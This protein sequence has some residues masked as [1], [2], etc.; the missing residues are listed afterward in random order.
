M[1]VWKVEDADEDWLYEAIERAEELFAE[2]QR[3][4]KQAE[5]S[6]RAEVARLTKDNAVLERKEAE[7]RKEVDA[8]MAAREQAAEHGVQAKFAADRRNTTARRAVVGMRRAAANAKRWHAEEVKLG[9]ECSTFQCEAEAR[10]G[11]WEERTETLRALAADI[12]DLEE[13]ES[14]LEQE[15]SE[16][17]SLGAARVRENQ[18][19]MEALRSQIAESTFELQQQRRAKELEELMKSSHEGM[20]SADLVRCIMEQE[21]L[22]NNMERR[23]LA[24]IE[25]LRYELE[26]GAVEE[27]QLRRK[28]EHVDSSNRGLRAKLLSQ[29]Q[30]V[31]QMRQLQEED[32]LW[33]THLKQ[34]ANT[35]I[36][37]VQ[38]LKVE[39]TAYILNVEHGSDMARLAAKVQH[40]RRRAG[41]EL[42]TNLSMCNNLRDV[43]RVAENAGDKFQGV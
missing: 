18:A 26:Q 23:S 34:T 24:A 7:R 17:T 22:M 42:A 25:G 41:E 38:T 10:R 15:R 1:A 11:S 29:A 28:L 4:Q 33:I 21:Q 40:R 30:Y 2:K 6:L 32:E 36:D 9:E 5:A 19:E 3:R 14:T 43:L 37:E 27:V 20:S 35:L 13:Q 12:A 16:E 8:E 39:S 31:V